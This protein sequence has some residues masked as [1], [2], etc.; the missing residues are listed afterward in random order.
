MNT[1]LFNKDQSVGEIV[2]ILPKSSKLFK[3]LKIDF[4]CGGDKTLEAAANENKLNLDEVMEKLEVIYSKSREIKEDTDFREMKLSDLIDY[5]EQTHH[6]YVKRSLPEIGEYINA[7]LNAHGISHSE[8]FKV[9]KLYNTLRTE[10]E[11]HLV[12]EEKVLFPM[13]KEYEEFPSNDYLKKIIEAMRE[14]EEEHENAGDVL[15]EL[16]KT[17][18]EYMV[19]ED[20]CATY[21]VTYDKLSEFESDLFEHIHLENNIMF[22]RLEEY[23]N[24]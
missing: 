14:T 15:K 7:I 16:R 5:I 11:Q 19:P 8:L 9:H 17:T 13:I 10:L 21:C 3:E 23:L 18:R 6:I 2:A 1:T 24:K 22:K 12:K 4:C 20:G